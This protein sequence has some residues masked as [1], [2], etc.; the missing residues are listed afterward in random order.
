MFS[1]AT[2]EKSSDFHHSS[3]LVTVIQAIFFFIFHLS[4]FFIFSTVR[5]FCF[6]FTPQ[7]LIW[8]FSAPVVCCLGYKALPYGIIVLYSFPSMQRRASVPW[9]E[10]GGSILHI[11]NYRFPLPSLGIYEFSSKTPLMQ[12]STQI[13]TTIEGFALTETYLICSLMSATCSLGLLSLLLVCWQ[14][15][16]NCLC[17]VDLLQCE[18]AVS[19]LL[20]SVT[21]SGER[22]KHYCTPP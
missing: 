15:G 11:S 22:H 16:S 17:K 10:D 3:L 13:N 7:Q 12:L 18:I 14:S 2:S 4:V 19:L 1:S 9:E 5:K 6:H 20:I 21:P 8:P